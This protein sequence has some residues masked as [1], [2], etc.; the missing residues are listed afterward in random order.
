[1]KRKTEMQVVKLAGNTYVRGDCVAGCQA[2]IQDETVDL[3]VTDPPYG[4]GGGAL[5]KHYN[6]DEKFVLEGYIDI[7]ADQYQDFSLAWIAQAARILKPG[8]QI[9]I[10]SGYTHLYEIMHALRQT[11]LVEVNHL[12][13]KYPFGVYTRRKFITSHYH[14]LLYARPPLEKSTFNLCSRFGIE[15]RDADGRSLNYRDREDVWTINRRYQPGKIKNKN[16]L[17]QELLVK[18]LQ[19]SSSEG[20]LVCDLF[21]GGF[22]TAKACIGLNR[23]FIGFE[24]SQR[25]FE[26]QIV[27]ISQLEPGNLLSKLR[28]PATDR[29]TNRGGAWSEKDKRKLLREYQGLIRAGLKQKEALAQLSGKYLRGEWSLKRVLKAGQK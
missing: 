10:V 7:P 12:V 18:I 8:G 26:H 11:P 13:W 6:R 15:E 21:M 25:A 28:K 3:I 14:I 20:D 4:I 27:E 5:H 29:L 23:R 2:L 16:E 19:Y 22:T 24:L 17:P 1:M 9:Y